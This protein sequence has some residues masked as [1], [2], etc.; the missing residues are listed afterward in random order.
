MKYVHKKIGVIASL[1][2][3]AGLSL[4][5][6]YYAD[7]ADYAE[8]R[9]TVDH[10]VI[11]EVAL[12]TLD[13]MARWFELYNPTD[14]PISLNNWSYSF[15]FIYAYMW[16]LFPL[17]LTVPPHGYVVITPSIKNFTAYWG[18]RIDNVYVADVAYNPET[19]IYIVGN[20]TVVDSMGETP[21]YYA[22]NHAWA[23]YRGG[24]DTDNF[25]NDFYDEPGPTPGRENRRA[26]VVQRDAVDAVE[27]WLFISTLL[28]LGAAVL[29][30]MSLMPRT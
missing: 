18:V 26:K 9:P 12:N 15:A 7:Y 14:E 29:W 1:L 10:L 25:T 22:L 23:R 11:N 8:M 6:V 4:F 17:N 13:P 20:H 30:Y 3:L 19:Y 27:L 24:Y 28:C 2:L 5:S 21:P 16:C